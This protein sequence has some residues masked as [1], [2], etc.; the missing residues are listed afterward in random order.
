MD[1]RQDASLNTTLDRLEAWAIARD[2]TPEVAREA[3]NAT[4][5]VLSRSAAPRWGQAEERRAEAYFSA[6]L[7]RRAVRRGQPP[8]AAAR[9]VV[10]AIVEDL[11]ASGRDGEAIWDQLERGWSDRFPCDVLE[12]Y[13]LRLC[14]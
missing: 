8:R 2:V 7:R 5:R 1:S 6:V 10:A 12:E 9:F 14:G 11:R 3:R 13:R 4:K